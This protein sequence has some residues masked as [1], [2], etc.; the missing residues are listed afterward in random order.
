MRAL[1]PALLCAAGVS[2]A[3]EPGE[4]IPHAIEAQPQIIAA[5]APW[6]LVRRAEQV[7]ADEV[8]A[9][10]L[11]ALSG[12]IE[13]GELAAAQAVV[14]RLQTQTLSGFQRRALRFQSALLA[15]Q[16]GRHARAIEFLRGLD[17]SLAVDAND[18]PDAAAE[19]AE[20]LRLLADSQMALRRNAD[21]L[22]TLLRRD[23]LAL[24]DRAANQ[25]Q[26]MALLD[27]LDPLRRQL[28]LEDPPFPELPGWLALN[29][30]L[31]A[32][33]PADRAGAIRGWQTRHPQHPARRFVADQR[34]AGLPEPAMTVAATGATGAAATVAKI[35][36]PG[37]PPAKIAKPG[38][39][40]PRAT[41][42][43]PPTPK[44]RH[45]AL[46]LPLTSSFG[47]AAQAFFEGFMAA[48]RDDW[49]DHGRGDGD[50]DGDQNDH[51]GDGAGAGGQNDQGGDE[52]TQPPLITLHDIGADAELVGFYYRAALAGGA[53]F[54]VG[55]L[56]RQAVNALLAGPPLDL[57]V[58]MVGEVPAAR[59]APNLYGISL[60][61]EREAAQVAARA[62]FHGHR[63]AGLLTGESDEARRAAAAFAAAWRTLGGQVVASR[64]VPRAVAGYARAAQTLLGIDRSIAREKILTAQMEIDLVF[65]PRRRDD[66][67]FLF[68]AASAADARLLVPHLRFYQAH[69]LPLYATSRVYGG[70]P[71]PAT[72]ADL[73][74]IIFGDL[75]WVI[76]AAK[77]PR[78][79]A[80]VSTDPPLDSMAG[81]TPTSPA[82]ASPTAAT[83]TPGARALGAYFHT[84]LDRLYALG[85]ESYRL[86]PELESLRAQPARRHYG[87]AVDVSVGADGNARRHLTWA[88]FERGLPLRLP[89]ATAGV[90]L[91]AR[92]GGGIQ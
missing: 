6:A 86:I 34:L 85:L 63:Q 16:L 39:P 13:G 61:P 43:T 28:F 36:K 82:S 33:R 5:D 70:A 35:A 24:P 1:L 60:S 3:Q 74:G 49:A 19:H 44:Y 71:D 56:G 25:M 40:P 18:A 79:A 69:D 88:R 4:A 87:A 30:I 92:L 77:R 59:V 76:D 68:L 2:F 27:S 54:V 37:A 8:A 89:G 22:L 57:P 65:T 66:I 12:F 73:D 17:I 46:L 78:P 51:G 9:L 29:D 72:D 10:L 45:I 41:V 21:A 14:E 47:A 7:A 80:V 75:A 53:D 26:I 62:F 83:E 50:G 91:D 32:A 20:I 11:P 42:S 90:P 55:P 84:G 48:H 15:Q 52:S 58:L 64:A 38:A 23:A 81:A 31:R 67:D